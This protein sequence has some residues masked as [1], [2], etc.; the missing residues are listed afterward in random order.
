MVVTDSVSVRR[1]Q[2]LPQTAEPVDVVVT[3]VRSP[4]PPYSAPAVQ[5]S[6]AANVN[7]GVYN[8]SSSEESGNASNQPPAADVNNQALQEMLLTEGRL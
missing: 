1:A 6:G 7:G 8:F 3:G 2:S 4:P 5:C